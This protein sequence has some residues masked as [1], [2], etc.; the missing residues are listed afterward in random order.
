MQEYVGYVGT[1][2][3]GPALIGVTVVGSKKYVP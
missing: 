2:V 3:T 1:I